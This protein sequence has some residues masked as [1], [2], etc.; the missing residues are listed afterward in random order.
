MSKKIYHAVWYMN[1]RKTGTVYEQAVGYYLEQQGYEILQYNYRCRAGEIDIVARDGTYIVFCEVKYRK[2][3][4]AGHA[5][6]AVDE[7]KQRVICRC[8]LFYIMEHHL[9]EDMEYRFD[10]VA[11]EKEK[12]V[13]VQDAFPFHS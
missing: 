6:A 7:K 12:I 13:V 1:N 3:R 4:G 8:A 9:A 11:I 2:G 10:V 5:L